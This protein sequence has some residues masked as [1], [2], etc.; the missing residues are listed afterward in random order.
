MTS[1]YNPF[2]NPCAFCGG[3]WSDAMLGRHNGDHQWTSQTLAE[4]Q[5]AAHD[6]QP[7]DLGTVALHNSRY[8]PKCR[9]EVTA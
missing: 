3:E 9:E 4:R 7:S 1:K 5:A 6:N 8:C 2:S